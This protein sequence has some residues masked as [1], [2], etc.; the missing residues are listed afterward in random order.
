MEWQHIRDNSR[1]ARKEHRCY[2]CEEPILVGSPYVARTG[3]S[4]DS[5]VTFHMHELCNAFTGAEWDEDD[6][7]YHT[8]GAGFRQS[9]HEWLDDQERKVK[10]DSH[11]TPTA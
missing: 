6:W 8:D 7:E 5:I 1:T 4:D 3:V 2:L 9:L 11:P 10:E